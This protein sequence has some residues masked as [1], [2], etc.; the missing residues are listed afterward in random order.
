MTIVT[1]FHGPL[2]VYNRSGGLLYRNRSHHSYWDVD[3]VRGTKSTYVY[4][5]TD[6]LTRSECHADTK[7]VR[8][9]VEEINLTTGRVNSIFSR[10]RRGTINNEWHDIDR[11]NDTHY[12]IADIKRNEAYIV[13]VRTGVTVWR[14]NAQ[15]AFP[16]SSGGSNAFG[17][18]FPGDWT[19]LNDIEVLDDGRI[20]LSLRNQDAVIFIN[21]TTGFQKNWTLGSDNEYDI[22]YEQHN[23]DYISKSNGGPAVVLADSQNNRIVEYQRTDGKWEQTWV[24]SD[25][26]ML[27]PRDADRLP[28]G[29][30]LITDTNSG[31][32]IEVNKSGKKKTVI[33]YHGP[34]RIYE[35]ER[36]GTGDESA[37]GPSA[38][39]A[40]L[41]SRGMTTVD[42]KASHTIER[43]RLQNLWSGVKQVLPTKILNAIMFVKPTWLTFSD[44][45]R[46]IG[47]GIVIA[48]W[49]CLELLWTTLSISIQSPVRVHR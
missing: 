23:P 9:V 6:V 49:V 29:N 39:T 31:R 21:R 40:N 5:A 43:S 45:G 19:H 18:N 37:G 32:I 4:S 17:T 13:N 2:S 46:M 16:L 35:S 33:N 3:P 38:R 25:S 8:N 34:G 48:A 44:I 28:N 47:I 12:A 11:I 36:V 41:Q 15:D 7:C 27:W 30:T 20:M 22:M 24:W 10:I 1:A 26:E 42:G 14:W